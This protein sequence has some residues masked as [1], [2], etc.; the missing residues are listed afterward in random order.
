MS[1]VLALKRWRQENHPQWHSK[2]KSSL[3]Y[4]RLCTHTHTHPWRIVC[5]CICAQMW[6]SAVKKQI[7][8]RVKKHEESLQTKV[9]LISRGSHEMSLNASLSS[10]Y[11]Q[12]PWFSNL[13]SHIY[14][15]GV[16]HRK[17]Q[18]EGE[19]HPKHKQS[20]E[21]K[22]LYPQPPSFSRIHEDLEDFELRMKFIFTHQALCS[23]WLFSH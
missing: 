2:L 18:Q 5:V 4:L 6:K 1:I 21:R 23:I 22:A 17:Q 7:N 15:K 11:P 16:I 13:S 8:A 9:P 12:A 3:G 19:V 14:Y 10:I 20:S